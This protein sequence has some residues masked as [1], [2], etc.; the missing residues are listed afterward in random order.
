MKRRRRR[1][2]FM[3]GLT[4]LEIRWLQSMGSRNT[5][6]NYKMGWNKFKEYLEKTAEEILA[7]RKT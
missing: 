4:E 3:N 2:D 5:R 1:N 6:R 7:E